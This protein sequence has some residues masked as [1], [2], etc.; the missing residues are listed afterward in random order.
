[1]QRCTQH[2]ETGQQLI[3]AALSYRDAS[4]GAK[5]DCEK[6]HELGTHCCRERGYSV[7]LGELSQQPMAKLAPLQGTEMQADASRRQ[8]AFASYACADEFRDWKA[9]KTCWQ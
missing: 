6:K 5:N 4:T 7:C 1:M 3:D 8:R 9:E 2:T